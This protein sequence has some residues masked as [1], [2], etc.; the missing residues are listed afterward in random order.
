M[1]MVGLARLEAEGADHARVPTHMRSPHMVFVKNSKSGPIDGLYPIA[2]L[3]VIHI[4]TR[5]SLS[6]HSLVRAVRMTG[7]FYG[8]DPRDC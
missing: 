3:R 7:V 2:I 6:E 1:T 8:V 4:C 5:A